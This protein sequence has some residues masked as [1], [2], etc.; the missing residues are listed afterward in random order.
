M[1]KALVVIAGIAVLAAIAA[2]AAAWVSGGEEGG[3]GDEVV[4]EAS[5]SGS[6]VEVS[7]GTAITITLDSNV[8]TGFQWQLAGDLDESVLKLEGNE[9]VGLE[10]VEGSEPI[11]GAGGQEVWTFTA[12]GPGEANLRLKYAQPWAGGMESDDTFE[13]TV[14]VK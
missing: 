2:L 9:Y 5:D 8:T 13:V 6:E 3:N 12:A 14:S 1:K 10:D 11:A 4:L 7:E